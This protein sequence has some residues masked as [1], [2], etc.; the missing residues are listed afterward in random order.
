MPARS[1]EEAVRLATEG[2]NSGDI[3]AIL[4]LYEPKASFLAQPGQ[5]GTG[6]DALRQGFTAFLAM[7]PRMKIDSIRVVPGGDD[8]ALVMLK[9]HFSGIGPDGKAMTMAGH[10]SDVARRQRDGT[11]LWVIDN[12]WGTA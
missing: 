10:S 6:T 5:I 3:N 9:W 11:W 1:P 12:P 7:K 2:L 4:A 8:I